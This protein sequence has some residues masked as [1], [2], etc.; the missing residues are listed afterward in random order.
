MKTY[1]R[2]N[3]QNLVTQRIRSAVEQEGAIE[4]DWEI[5]VS[6]G[7]GY[8]YNISTREWVDARTEQQKYQSA[9]TVVVERR[10]KLLYATDWT[11][12]PN[13]P[14]SAEQQQAWAVYRQQL[15]DLTEQSGFP[16]EVSWPTAPSSS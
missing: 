6:P 4:I 13:G 2:V 16:G 14:L 15:R 9:A 3:E 7:E 5:G 12:L 1:V 8:A 11:Q 10:N